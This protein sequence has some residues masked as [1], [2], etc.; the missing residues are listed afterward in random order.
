MTDWLSAV[1]HDEEA[2][3]N[4][5]AHGRALTAAKAR[6]EKRYVAYLRKASTEKE[7]DDRFAFINP[8]L[9]QTVDEACQEHR[10]ADA[11]PI[12]DAT[13]AH[14]REV[15]SHPGCTGEGCKFCEN[16]SNPPW[17]HKTRDTDMTDDEIAE[18]DDADELERLKNS[19][20]DNPACPHCGGSGEADSGGDCSRCH[21][22]GEIEIKDKE[23]RVG[24]LWD[25]IG[26]HTAAEPHSHG[27]KA[28]KRVSPGKAIGGGDASAVADMPGTAVADITSDLKS[29]RHPSEMQD[30]TKGDETT[31]LKN[32]D[33]GL[34][35]LKSP[36]KMVDAQEPIG[37]ELVGE[38]GTFDSSPRAADPV[39]SKWH[40]YEV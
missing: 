33:A 40:L 36:S 4:E 34:D 17:M 15:V 29:I 28:E 22:S 18:E 25:N 20:V 2:E 14:L 21:G 1:F 39:T 11:K 5:R 31:G 26:E 27:D 3:H 37:K 32:N 24:D 8:A 19:K 38:G 23:S 9:L 10:F 13:L 35:G 12:Y 30:V 7:L 16:K 6:V